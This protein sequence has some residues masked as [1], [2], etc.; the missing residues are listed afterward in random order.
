MHYF[1][2]LSFL[3]CNRLVSSPRMDQPQTLLHTPVDAPAQK[4]GR[5]EEA[6][7]GY[8]GYGDFASI[9]VNETY[10]GP[11]EVP[12]LPECILRNG[13]EGLDEFENAG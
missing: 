6:K 3:W 10:R 7:E 9:V 11:N 1:A 12:G 8:R 2:G 4:T 13:T 5:A